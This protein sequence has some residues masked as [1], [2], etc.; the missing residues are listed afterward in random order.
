SMSCL[1]CAK[2]R[3]SLPFSTPSGIGSN[4]PGLWTKT[5]TDHDKSAIPTIRLRN[6][7]S[8]PSTVNIAVV[9]DRV[10][11]SSNLSAGQHPTRQ[12]LRLG[13]RRLRPR[14]QL[15]ELAL[16]RLQDGFE[17]VDLVQRDR[18]LTLDIEERRLDVR[19]LRQ[20]FVHLGL[21]LVELLGDLAQ[22]RGPLGDEV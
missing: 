21:R 2:L 1:S 10:V 11:A 19:L 12:F 15:Q 14:W 5:D 6:A 4:H 16:S 8:L 3:G 9:P 22:L 20:Q 18:H 13:R 7:R 17:P